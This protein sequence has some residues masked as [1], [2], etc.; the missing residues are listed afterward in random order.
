[1]TK[2]DKLINKPIIILTFAAAMIERIWHV[3]YCITWGR[4][5]AKSV[6]WRWYVFSMALSDSMRL[7]MLRAHAFPMGL[8]RAVC[9]LRTVSTLYLIVWARII[10]C[11]WNSCKSYIVNHESLKNHLFCSSISCVIINTHN[12][13]QRYFSHETQSTKILFCH[14]LLFLLI[15]RA[16]L[17]NTDL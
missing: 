4:L 5:S 8:P 7:Q 12:R 14:K 10:P 15:K 13:N 2:I 1:M 16:A 9:R 6:L 3:R 11:W 17:L